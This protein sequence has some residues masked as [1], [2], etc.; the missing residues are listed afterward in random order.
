MNTT[1]DVND[2]TCDATHCSLREAIIAANAH[3][4]GD[5]PDDITFAIAGTGEQQISV[6]SSPLPAITDPVS[7]DGETERSTGTNIP[8]GSKAIVLNGDGAGSTG[9]GLVLATGSVGRR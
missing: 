5:G 4:N 1:N 3:A 2:G 6:L 9:D 8:E 7:I